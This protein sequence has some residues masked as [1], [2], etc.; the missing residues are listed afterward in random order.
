MGTNRS[1]GTGASFSICT[2]K[3][4]PRCTFYHLVGM[5]IEDRAYACGTSRCV[6]FGNITVYEV[7]VLPGKIC[8]EALLGRLQVI[9][10]F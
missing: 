4:S 7:R 1:G 9:S 10:N 5:V 6:Y 3:N 8:P 2:R